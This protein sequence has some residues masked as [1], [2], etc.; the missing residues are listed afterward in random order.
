MFIYNVT[1]QVTHAIHNDWKNWMLQTH[2]PEVMATECFEKFQFVRMLEVDETEG[3]TYA[4]Q[5]Y[6]P[7]KAMYNR[8]I[9]KYAAAL[10]QKTFDM[11]GNQ[12]IAFRSLM[13]IVE[14][15]K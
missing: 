15:D 9:D 1:I 5:Y 3:I 14:T 10:R 6:A 4:V 13:Q 11:W 7:A 2:I 8:Y 12:F